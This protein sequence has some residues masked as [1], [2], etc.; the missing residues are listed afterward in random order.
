MGNVVCTIEWDPSVYDNTY[1]R[2]LKEIANNHQLPE[3]G[4]NMMHYTRGKSLYAVEISGF[5]IPWNGGTEKVKKL[6]KAYAYDAELVLRHMDAT[7][8]ESTIEYLPM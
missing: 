5:S 8:V 4:S 7:G 2:N 6:M 3:A 1:T